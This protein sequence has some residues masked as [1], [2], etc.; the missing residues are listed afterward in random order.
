MPY[1]KLDDPE[2]GMLS[3]RLSV[4]FVCYEYAWTVAKLYTAYK[5][6]IS[7][8]RRGNYLTIELY[9]YCIRLTGMQV[10]DVLGTLGR[11]TGSQPAS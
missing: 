7:V 2:L 8:Q 11:R 9:L 5:N 10:P 6:R 4:S 1:C 3:F